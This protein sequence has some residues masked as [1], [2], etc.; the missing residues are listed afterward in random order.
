MHAT[1]G[2]PSHHENL[3]QDVK[4]VL[5]T[6]VELSRLKKQAHAETLAAHAET[7]AAHA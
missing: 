6:H 7:L 2:Y 1:G 3:L 5:Y 4:N